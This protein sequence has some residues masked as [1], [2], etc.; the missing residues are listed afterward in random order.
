MKQST[1][2]DK[3]NMPEGYRIAVDG[4]AIMIHGKNASG[5]APIIVKSEHI[6]Q[7]M[8]DLDCAVNDLAMNRKGAA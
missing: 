3:L 8:A 1:K 2:I 6:E 7:F 5:F 4:T